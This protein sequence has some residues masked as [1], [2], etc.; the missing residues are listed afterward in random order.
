M[1]TEI[2]ISGGETY[3]NSVVWNGNN[4]QDNHGTNFGDISK[5]NIQVFL[6][7]YN[8]ENNYLDESLARKIGENQPPNKPLISGPNIG[9]FNIQYNYTIFTIDPENDNIY[10]FIDWG[11]GHTQGWL[12][13]YVSGQEIILSHVFEQN[14]FYE[15]KVKAKDEN[16]AESYW[17]R[18]FYVTIGNVPPDEPE[19]SGPNSGKIG[20]SY[21]YT[22]ITNDKNGDDIYY[23]NIEWGDG[24]NT[25]LLG[26]YESGEFVTVN[27]IWSEKGTYNIRAKAVDVHGS[28]SDWGEMRVTMPRNHFIKYRFQNLFYFIKELLE[29]L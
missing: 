16:E 12:G 26:P 29:L 7:V 1:N 9:I 21:E 22:F 15:I 17:S 27:H 19:I 25:S 23:A 11:D 14:G 18:P 10:Y 20:D 5:D 3:T 8:L 24:S 4:H 13:P 28:E 2:T 6:N